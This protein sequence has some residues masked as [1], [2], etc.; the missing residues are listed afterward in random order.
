MFKALKYLIAILGFAV[1]VG[2]GPSWAQNSTTLEPI[3]VAQQ[4]CPSGMNACNR[5][6]WGPG[7]C[8]KSGYASCANGLICSSGMRQCGPGAW[9]RGGCYRP[10]Y[11]SCANGLVCSSG[12]Q[13]CAPGSAGRGGMLSA[14]QPPLY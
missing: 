12:M 3:L 7:G 5:G 2:N 1:V 14:R 9:G 4:R 10:G 11:A 8:Y 13:Q 6:P